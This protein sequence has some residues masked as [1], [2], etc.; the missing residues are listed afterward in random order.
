MAWMETDYSKRYALSMEDKMA[1]GAFGRAR[2]YGCG[3]TFKYKMKRV[4]KNNRTKISLMGGEG[5][6]RRRNCSKMPNEKVRDSFTVPK[7]EARLVGTPPYRYPLSLS[8]HYFS[9]IPNSSP[10]FS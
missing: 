7:G 4:R 3:G 8:L 6:G 10:K 9:V 5:E 2:N 1:T